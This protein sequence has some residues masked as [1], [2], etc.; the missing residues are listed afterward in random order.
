MKIADQMM[1]KIYNKHGTLIKDN[2]RLLLP[3]V[4]LAIELE[5]VV[6][7]HTKLV[8]RDPFIQ[9]TFTP[10]SF[11]PSE[12]LHC[13]CDN[14]IKSRKPLSESNKVYPYEQLS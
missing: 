5:G 1:Y 12:R 11:I 7:K 13:I 2:F 4:K 8:W 14:C 10:P 9:Y 3:G 6:Y